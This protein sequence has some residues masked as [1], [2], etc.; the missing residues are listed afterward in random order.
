MTHLPR[1]FALRREL[2][3]ISWYVNIPCMLA[4]FIILNKVLLYFPHLRDT[5]LCEDHLNEYI[6]LISIRLFSWVA[7]GLLPP[8]SHWSPFVKYPCF[9]ECLYSGFPSSSLAYASALRTA[10]KIIWFLRKFPDSTWLRGSLTLGPP[11]LW[12]VSIDA[13]WYTCIHS[14]F[15]YL[16][17]QTKL[18]SYRE[19][20]FLS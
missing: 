20:F 14:L 4:V 16:Y 5:R 3:R 9:S 1:R 6:S 7:L 12:A 10:L 15:F 2:R 18:S 8:E 19:K 13:E 11:S 17:S